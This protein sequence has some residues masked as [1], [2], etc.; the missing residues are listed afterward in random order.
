MVTGKLTTL[1][2]SA[3]TALSQQMD[4]FAQVLLLDE[5]MLFTW[6]YTQGSRVR[7]QA[8]NASK[9]TTYISY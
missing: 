3:S 9:T 6:K 1:Q 7:F 4:S 5:F 8:V 2:M